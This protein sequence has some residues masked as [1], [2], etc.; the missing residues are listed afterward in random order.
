M[1]SSEIAACAPAE[2]AATAWPS[3][4]SN[5]STASEAPNQMPSGPG[6]M[7]ATS[8]TKR[9]NPIRTLTSNPNNLNTARQCTGGWCA[10]GPGSLHV[11]E[12]WTYQFESLDS[13]AVPYVYAFDFKH[14]KPPMTY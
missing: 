8:P 5:V 10:D 13:T 12:R 4:C 9:R 2:R 6:L 3:S 14:R 1:K 7:K 11:R